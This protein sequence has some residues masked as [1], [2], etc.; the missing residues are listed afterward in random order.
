MSMCVLPDHMLLC[1]I[2]CHS[3]FNF[4][5]NIRSLLSFLWADHEE[6]MGVQ[7]GV[8]TLVI[9][10]NLGEIE[11]TTP[12][13]S[14][15]NLLFWGVCVIGLIGRRTRALDHLV[16]FIIFTII[17][18]V[19]TGVIGRKV[20]VGDWRRSKLQAGETSA[21]VSPLAPCSYHLAVRL[22]QIVYFFLVGWVGWRLKWNEWVWWWCGV[23]G[24][25]DVGEEVGGMSEALLPTCALIAP[26]WSMFY[27][28]SWMCHGFL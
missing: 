17:M 5:Q 18:C 26:V 11:W 22:T 7:F 20:E 21:S 9:W 24:V 6:D 1:K 19:V 28:Y 3:I 25:G 13:L 12:F 16:I 10:T 14:F 8:S 4:A 2:C 27:F 23:G 15:G